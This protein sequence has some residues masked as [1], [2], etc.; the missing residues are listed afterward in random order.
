MLGW[1]LGLLGLD[2]H[3]KK[4]YFSRYNIFT[5]NLMFY[6]GLGRREWVDRIEWVQMMP[7]KLGR[8]SW[9]SVLLLGLLGSVFHSKYMYYSQ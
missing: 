8:C 9:G 4:G 1:L 5:Y 2:F 7:S 3:G 6:V